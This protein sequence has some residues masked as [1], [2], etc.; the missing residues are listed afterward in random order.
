MSKKESFNQINY[1]IRPKKQIE[2]KILIDILRKLEFLKSLHIDDYRYLGFGS[3]FYFDFVMFHK[4]LNIKKMTSLDYSKSRKRCEFN[5]PYDFIDFHNKKSTDFL[6]TMNYSDNIF[7]WLDYD[8]KFYQYNFDPVKKR[9]I[10]QMNSS[11]FDDMELFNTKAKAMDI[12]SVSLNIKMNFRKDILEEFINDYGRY[13]P[14]RFQNHKEITKTNFSQVAQLILLNKFQELTRFEDIKFIKL[15]SF[16]YADGIPMYTLGGIFDK[17]QN[18][19][20][21]KE[22]ESEFIN[23]KKDYVTF[24]NTPILTIKEKYYLENMIFKIIEARDD[25]EQ[26]E[27]LFHSLDF[28]L[29]S[30]DSLINFSSYYKYY[31]Q[32]FEGLV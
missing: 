31:P 30:I 4:Y 27:K 11:L 25:N 15:F 20:Q 2:R 24:I 10:C 5:K 18:I 7:A 23:L 32:Y 29:E 9:Y 28:E 12:F 3:I 19:S 1:S 17:K 6:S 21:Y 16:E 14:A 13:L 22:N 26:L 8:S